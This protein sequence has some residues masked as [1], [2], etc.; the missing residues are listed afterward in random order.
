MQFGEKAVVRQN[1]DIGK[2]AGLAPRAKQLQQV[3]AQGGGMLRMG[4]QQIS[5]SA[6]AGNRFF[7]C[8]MGA[9]GLDQI[10]QVVEFR[11]IGGEQ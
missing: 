8:R 10:D 9:Q 5:Q 4:L 3:V 11:G 6:E 2:Q 1:A 7:L